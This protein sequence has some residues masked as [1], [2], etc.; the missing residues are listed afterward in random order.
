MRNQRSGS[1]LQ[2][3]KRTSVGKRLKGETMPIQYLLVN[4]PDQ[5]AVLADGN[6]VGFTNHMLMLPADEYAITL[7]GTGYQPPSRDV[8][9]AGTSIVKPM[10]VTFSPIVASVATQSQAPQTVTP[11]KTNA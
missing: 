10:V 9:L 6:G 11:V 5:R 3:A 7:D 2:A 8:V 4:F 1:G